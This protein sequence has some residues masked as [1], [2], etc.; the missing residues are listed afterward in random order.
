MADVSHYK[1]Y[2]TGKSSV[3][4]IPNTPTSVAVTFDVP[5]KVVPRVVATASTT[6]PGSTV[7]EV[8]VGNVTVDGFDLFIYR[9]NSTATNVN[10]IA[11]VGEVDVLSNV[12]KNDTYGETILGH[13]DEMVVSAGSDYTDIEAEWEIKNPNGA[14]IFSGENYFENRS[15]WKTPIVKT[16]MAGLPAGVYTIKYTYH[17]PGYGKVKDLFTVNILSGGIVEPGNGY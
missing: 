9:T 14:I 1:T 6:V 17:I 3:T 8:S 13:Y 7:I 4:P 11:Q 16:N 10:W 5:F 2:Q 12:N 15:G